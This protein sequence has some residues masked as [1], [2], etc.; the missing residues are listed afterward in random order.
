MCSSDLAFLYDEP[1]FLLQME[2][3]E[4]RVYF[5]I[6]EAVA[7]GRVRQNDIRQAVGINGA[8]LGYY[9]GALR[10]LGLLERIVPVTE[11][12]PARSRQ[13]LYHLLD[14]FFRFWFRFVYRERVHL[15][16]GD[17]AV[18][19]RAVE[20]QLEALTGLAFEDL[21]R[22]RVWDLAAEGRIPFE[23]QRVGRWWDSQAQVDV[24]A[25]NDEYLLLGECRWRSRPM[26]DDILAELKRK[27]V[28]VAG[29]E[30]AGRR[31]RVLALFS[32]TGFTETLQEIGRASCRERV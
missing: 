29:Q 22:A 15:E 21:C 1:R 24:A 17:T 23:P 30:G 26:G 25:L 18:V 6:L 11:A 8:S 2:L 27:A 3:L 10:D 13:G 32:R 4:Q 7:T 16:R 9:L 14:P 19:R 5:T 31:R 12:D 20:D 28:R